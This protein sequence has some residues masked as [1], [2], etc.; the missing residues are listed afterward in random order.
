MGEAL[1]AGS[2]WFL[3][4]ERLIN[5]DQFSLF[6]ISDGSICGVT[7]GTTIIIKEFPTEEEARNG[8]VFLLAEIEK[9]GNRKAQTDQPS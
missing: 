9:N 6:F 4:E 7:A 2:N 3:F 5:R 8:L 1:M